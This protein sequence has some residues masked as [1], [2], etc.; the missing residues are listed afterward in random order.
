MQIRGTSLVLLA[1]SA[2]PACGYSQQEWDAQLDKYNHLFAKHRASETELADKRQKLDEEQRRVDELMQQ[3]KTAG[4]D[5]RQLSEQLQSS[6][7]EVS[8]LSSSLEQLEKALQE[9][10][11][12]A[13]QLDAIR[14]RFELLRKKLEG[15]TKLGL[16]VNVRN[17]KLVI[18][19]PGDV[20]FD[21]A[22]DDIKDEGKE[23]LLKVAGVIKGDESLVGRSYQVAG[24]TDDRPL[25]G[26]RF[27][28]NWGLSLMR[29]RQVL[30]FLVDPAEGAV[31]PA[32]WSAAGY[33]DSDPVVANDTDE[34]RQKNRRCELVVLPSLEEMLDLKSLAN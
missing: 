23:I 12:R 18:S 8:K 27:K 22:K 5:L 13:K 29:A 17:N 21:T 11:A 26:G 4:V 30:L 15:L 31:P 25:K 32:K 19:L 16:A 9:Y 2:L 14:T 3:L 28:D 7:S 1:L 33:S 6:N 20:L 24:H 34:N 10:Q